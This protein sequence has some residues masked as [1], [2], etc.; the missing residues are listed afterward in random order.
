MRVSK[1]S[2]SIVVICFFS[3][4]VSI[5]PWEIF[6][7]STYIDRENYYRYITYHTNKI[8]W[9]DYSSFVSLISYE[10]L[11]HFL[12]KFFS[13]TLGVSANSIFFAISIFVTYVFSKTISINKGVF[14]ILLL[15]TPSFIDF[16]QSQLRL[17]LA[18]SLIYLS[19]ILIKNKNNK[20]TPL[21]L[22][23]FAPF[24]HTSSIVFISFGL[25]SYFINSKLKSE[26][27]KLVFLS[28]YGFFIAFVLGPMRSL[29]LGYFDDRRAEYSDMSSPVVNVL[30]WIVVYFGIIWC[31]VT[32]KIKI[33]FELGVSIIVSGLI[34][35]NIF[36]L[37][38]SS[39][40]ISATLPFLL[41]GLL[42]LVQPVKNI[43]LLG[44]FLFV[45]FLWVFW[46]Y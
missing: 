37:G 26:I 28:F 5:I 2:F 29:I 33:N 19:Y 31:V 13:N 41:I 7:S 10:W 16:S 38:Y 15:L 17:S 23:I 11:W 8:E 32:N 21:L 6:R 35:S 42:S 34:F 9:F 46:V 1:S 36:F 3:F 18:I 30:F 12:L 44:Y 14:F 43:A 24:I 20:I 45:S 25:V 22:I 27:S 4:L 40:F 39:R